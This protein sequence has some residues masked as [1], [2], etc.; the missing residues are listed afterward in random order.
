MNPASVIILWS[1]PHES[2]TNALPRS[3]VNFRK[4]ALSE[5][6]AREEKRSEQQCFFSGFSCRETFGP[7]MCRDP[8]WSETGT[9]S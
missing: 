4:F 6:P 8:S 7:L 2:W 3:I 1:N 9:R 5:L